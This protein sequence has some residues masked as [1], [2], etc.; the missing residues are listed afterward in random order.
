MATNDFQR[1]RGFLK[2]DPVAKWTSVIAGVGTGLL[3]LGYLFVLGLFADALVN[4]GAIPSLRNL[5][6][7][8]QQNFQTN[9]DRSSPEYW[10]RMLKGDSY[11]EQY[12]KFRLVTIMT[13][14][15]QELLEIEKKHRDGWNRMF[16]QKWKERLTLLGFSPE[17]ISLSTFDAF[18]NLA[19]TGAAGPYA[20]SSATELRQEILWR[21][22]VYAYL[23]ESVGSPAAELVNARS[24]AMIDEVGPELALVQDIP[25]CGIL[26]L[27]VRMQHRIDATP[28]AWLASINPW[29]WHDGIFLYLVGLLVFAIFLAAVRW[30]LIFLNEFFAAKA[31][32]EAVTRLRRAV[33]H[34]T[35]RL[36]TLAFHQGGPTEAVSIST[37]HIE[38]VHSGLYTWLTG[39]FREPIKFSLLLMFCLMVQPWLTL[40]FVMFALLVWMVGGQIASF[41]RGKGRKASEGSAEQLAL[42]QESLMILRLV[43]VYLMEVFNQARVERQFAKYSRSE[44]RKYWSDAIYLPMLLFMSTVAALT[45]LFVIGVV[46]TRGSLSMAGAI[47]LTTALVSLYLPFQRWLELRRSLRR[48]FASAQVVFEFLG[49]SGGVGQDIDAVFLPPMVKKIAFKNVT[50]RTPQSDKN[51]VEDIS[52]S[53][54]AGQ[55][56]GIVGSD[57]REKHALIYLIPRF[58]DPTSGQIMIDGRPLPSVTLESL[59]AQIAFVLQNSLIF[60]DTIANN[61]GCGEKSY[62]LAQIIEVAKIA[63]AHNFIQNLPKGY[64]T[65]IGEMGHPLEVSQQFRIALARAILRDPAILIIEEPLVPLDEEVKDLLDDT[66]SRVLPGRTVI[67]LPHRISTIKH[68]DKVFLIHDGKLVASGDH[69]TLLGSNEL[70]RHIQ[71][72]EFNEFVGVVKPTNHVP[73]K[74][75]VS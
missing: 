28:A 66:M 24:Q 6:P 18:A 21:W 29:T 43:K 75:T 46:V 38:A 16:V 44:M 74:S 63:R 56:V 9:V 37:R 26:S 15:D 65:V 69:K 1:A 7:A 60:N 52:L 61:I 54:R 49:K 71:Y 67:F 72:M 55:R 35:Y 8:Q 40:A 70:Y 62:A 30:I 2:F 3:Y 14:K 42:I 22:R 25:D 33:Y 23:E 13:G 50:L 64:E 39:H 4:R 31:T 68:C 17:K 11:A 73:E 58:L 57:E 48:A 12:D 51:L 59:R 47:T 10:E 34:H 27:I 5:P 32:L 19:A 20:T 45:L 36:G 41:F 53:I